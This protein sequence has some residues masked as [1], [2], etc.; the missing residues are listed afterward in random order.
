MPSLQ[1]E[2]KAVHRSYSRDA[3]LEHNGAWQPENEARAQSTQLAV[4]LALARGSKI[5][6]SPQE[7]KIKTL[8]HCH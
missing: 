2:K 4:T 6:P 5:M 7:E 8:R 3:R 1:K